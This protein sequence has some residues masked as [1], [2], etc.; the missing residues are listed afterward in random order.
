MYLNS[1]F[2]GL[3][4]LVL[5]VTQA[6]FLHANTVVSEG[7]AGPT[8]SCDSLTIIDTD[9]YNSD[10]AYCFIGGLYT[11]AVSPYTTAMSLDIFLLTPTLA[12]NLPLMDI[13]AATDDAD[14]FDGVNIWSGGTIQDV[15]S[16]SIMVG[17][18]SLGQIDEWSISAVGT[19]SLAG[20]TLESSWNGSSGSTVISDALLAENQNDPGNWSEVSPVPE[21]ATGV[22]LAIGLLAL[23]VLSIR[24]RRLCLHRRSAPPASI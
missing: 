9:Y 1:R 10:T 14:A 22:D 6:A 16:D 2:L 21:P 13:T 24:E 8:Y 17:T 12:P 5:C 15:S 7:F 19:G 18:N 4:L 3:F 11:D 20:Y 23:G